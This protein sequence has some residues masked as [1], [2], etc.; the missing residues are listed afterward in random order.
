MVVTV[1]SG[2]LRATAARPYRK[3]YDMATIEQVCARW[4]AVHTKSTDKGYRAGNECRVR[5]YRGDDSI[6]SYGTHFEMGR[7]LKDKRGYVTAFLLNGDTASVSTSN[8]QR[9]LRAAVDRSD[10]PRVI[11]SYAAMRA[12]GVELDTVR[13]LDASADRWETVNRVA[14]SAPAGAFHRA[15]G[16]LHVGYAPIAV[17]PLANGRT[18]YRWQDTR[19]RLGESV[20]RARVRAGRGWRTAKF[21]S[22]FDMQERA[23]LY[24]FC[25]L[26]RTR[27]VTVEEAYEA[28]K[29][30]VVRLAE[31]GGRTVTRQGDVFAVA[32]SSATT[33]RTLRGAGAT[34]AKH[35]RLL[36]TNHVATEVAHRPDGTTVVR[37]VLTHAPDGRRPDH[38]RVRLSDGWHV[39]AKN[40]VPLAA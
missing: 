38:R 20:I 17:T 5:T 15:D 14:Y 18:E 31:R 27:A 40:T 34:F 10:V 12:A 19:H 11:I 22:G 37:G 36:G 6:F 1:P 23:P 24:F 35:G 9:H 32:L 25:E 26:P 2:R 30:D 29:P 39:V 3:G 28:L 13:I 33:K 8:H 7:P 4:V 16:S 21:L